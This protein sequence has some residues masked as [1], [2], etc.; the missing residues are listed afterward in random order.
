MQCYLHQYLLKRDNELEIK[1]SFDENERVKK[2]TAV[3]VMQI[4][5][6][7]YVLNK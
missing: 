5:H 1:W 6:I 4:Q 7:M 3:I 2:I